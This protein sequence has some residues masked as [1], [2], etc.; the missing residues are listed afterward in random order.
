MAAGPFTNRFPLTNL[1]MFRDVWVNRMADDNPGPHFATAPAALV[2]AMGL[3]PD[4]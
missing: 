4:T 1:I 3:L 2:V